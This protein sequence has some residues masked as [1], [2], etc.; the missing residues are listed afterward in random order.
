VIIVTI[1]L[2]IIIISLYGRHLI[3]KG[4][5]RCRVQH[6][7]VKNKCDGSYRLSRLANDILNSDTFA[8]TF[9]YDEPEDWAKKRD[10][11]PNTKSKYRSR[12]VAIA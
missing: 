1:I 9:I 5:L 2:T 7:K 4:S 6:D 3:K 8:S 12:T 11:I 10:F